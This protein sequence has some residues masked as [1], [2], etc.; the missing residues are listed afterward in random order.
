MAGRGV[1]GQQDRLISTRER[2]RRLFR[3]D[4]SNSPQAPLFSPRE[5]NTQSNKHTTTVR[6]LVPLGK[7]TKYFSNR[8]S[9]CS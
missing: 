5:N 1:V 9:H 8:A 6:Q 4:R 2:R 7:T 3:L